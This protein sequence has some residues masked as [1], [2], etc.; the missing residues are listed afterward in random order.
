MTNITQ[1]VAYLTH[2]AASKVK[3]TTF[4]SDK[5]PFRQDL[6]KNLNSLIFSSSC[7]NICIIQDKMIAG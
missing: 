4:Y 7:L 6:Y 1:Y 3:V 2:I 5:K